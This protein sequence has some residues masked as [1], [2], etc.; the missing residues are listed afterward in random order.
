[1]AKNPCIFVLNGKTYTYDSFRKYLLDGGVE[2]HIP[3]YKFPK[4][5]TIKTPPAE[6]PQAEAQGNIPPANNTLNSAAGA[7]KRVPIAKPTSQLPKGAK[8]KLLSQMIAD[9]TSVLG[10]KISVG[11]TRAKNILGTYTP[12]N[13]LRKL[14]KA[15]S[16]ITAAHENAH[17]LD[18]KFKVL[19][20]ELG[21]AKLIKELDKHYDKGVYGEKPLEGFAGWME[22]Y[23][24]NPEQ[25]RANAPE[26]AKL[27]DRKVAAKDRAAVDAFSEDVRRFA[28][29]SAGDKYSAI[30]ETEVKPTSGYEKLKKVFGIKSYRD[31]QKNYLTVFE[32]LRNAW[33]DAL[34][35]IG[36]SESTLYGRDNFAT[37][38]KFM[39]GSD[40]RFNINLEKGLGD[41]NFKPIIDVKTG[42]RKTWSWIIGSDLKLPGA[43]H[44]LVINTTRHYMAAKRTIE[45]ARNLREKLYDE[46]VAKLDERI[47]TLSGENKIKILNDKIANLDRGKF[48]SDGAYNGVIKRYK[49]QISILEQQAKLNEGKIDILKGKRESLSPESMVIDETTITGVG[50]GMFSDIKIAEEKIK[51]MEDMARKSPRLYD[52]VIELDRRYKSVSDDILKYYLDSDV[53]SKEAYDMIKAKNQEYVA[54]QRVMEN[55]PME[56]VETD[57]SAASKIGSVSDLIKEFKGSSRTIIDPYASLLDNMYRHIRNA[58][59]NRTMRTF[60]DVLDAARDMYDGAVTNLA[61]IGYE[62]M[63]GDKYDLKVYKNGEPKYYVLNKDLV[64]GLDAINKAG[65]QLPLVMT[66]TQTVLKK[67]VTLSPQFLLRNPIRDQGSRL[68]ISQGKTS[69]KDYTKYGKSKEEYM[70]AGG[71][72][73][74]YFE[75]SRES[76]YKQ[77]K[78]ALKEASADNKVSMIPHKYIKAA[79]PISWYKGLLENSE[80][81][82]RTNEYKSVYRKMKGRGLNDVDAQLEAMRAA[83]ELIDFK[84]IG[85]NI[86]ALNCVI[87]FLNPKI[88]GFRVMIAAIKRNPVKFTTRMLIYGLGAEA[89]QTAIILSSSD[90]TK[91]RYKQLPAYRKN[92]FFNIPVGDGWLLIPKPFEYGAI[93]SAMG[94]GL[95]YMFLDDKNAYKNGF[96]RAV[97]SVM[98]PIDPSVIRGTTNPIT[99]VISNYDE[100]RGMHIVPIGEE[101]RDVELRKGREKASPIGEGLAVG[102]NKLGGNIDPRL[103]DFYIKSQFSYFGDMTIKS[104]E[105]IA[106]DKE[107]GWEV[108]SLYRTQNDLSSNDV[109]W[110]YDNAIRY[111]METNKDYKK[112]LTMSD[113]YN[114]A[115][116]EEEQNRIGLDIIATA[117]AIRKK[118]E[119]VDL[120]EAAK[121]REAEKQKEKEEK[122][123]KEKNPNRKKPSS[124]RGRGGISERGRRKGRGGL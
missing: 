27:Y 13:S 31:F 43:D 111:K 14:K 18:D 120:L 23:I 119:E 20:G 38:L 22:D 53:L 78:K 107:V 84:E 85:K 9:L 108:T 36:K 117:S 109:S 115:N 83:R 33:R 99:S 7:M 65:A 82:T 29:S 72:Q 58:D 45:F 68:F 102:I 49:T 116:T 64:D 96:T 10:G 75:R 123:K 54:L 12:S 51:E 94:R 98:N 6:K 26:I 4:G 41:V 17:F 110:I 5:K 44:S 77:M 55:S 113:E 35:E 93:M 90:E 118:W 121:K 3:G 104:S 24:L 21:N 46:A 105:A 2:E 92:M 88:Q 34:K 32:P 56:G 81:I 42:M 74:G 62:V 89:A 59:K 67:T 86:Q 50:G 95:D 71:G 103:I 16:I 122:E 1:M 124:D 80:L 69:L 106:G 79:N 48:K 52:A 112:I 37:M 15:N 60:T 76:Y 63:K 61:S 39:F 57:F 30:I 8:P 100:F 73:F 66:I 91:E 47:E 19:D 87:P 25:A 11:K 70:R 114:S 101:N 40:E 28:D 97:I